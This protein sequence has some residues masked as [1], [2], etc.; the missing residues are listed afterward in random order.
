M[1]PSLFSEKKENAVLFQ[2]AMSSELGVYNLLYTRNPEGRRFLLKARARAFA[3][4]NERVLN[5]K[6]Q[7]KGV[8]E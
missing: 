8:L 6:K 2:H 4:H 5:R 1:F 3:N 7:I